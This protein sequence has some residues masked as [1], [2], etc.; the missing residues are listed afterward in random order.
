M[1]IRQK[2]RTISVIERREIMENFIPYI[3]I[4][5]SFYSV[6]RLAV[7]SV[8]SN[9]HAIQ[10]H[11]QAKIRA[12]DYYRPTISIIVPAHNESTVIERTLSSLLRSEEH[13]S[14]LQ[15]QSNI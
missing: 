5:L 12:K 4:G 7:Y 14:E 1:A 15:S 13:T 3:I 6:L 8:S 9:M 2:I 10:Q 11:S